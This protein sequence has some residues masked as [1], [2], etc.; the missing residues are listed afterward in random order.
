MMARIGAWPWVVYTP[1]GKP[2]H[3]WRQDERAV[4]A[5]RRWGGGETGG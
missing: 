3:R 5:W 2:P 1:D 4:E